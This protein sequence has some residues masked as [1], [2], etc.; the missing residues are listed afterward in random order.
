MLHHSTE[1]VASIEA[2]DGRG[3]RKVT[4]KPIQTTSYA[5]LDP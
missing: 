2:A 3:Q 1:L 5:Q 4:G